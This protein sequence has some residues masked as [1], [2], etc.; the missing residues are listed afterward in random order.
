MEERKE[1]H[2]EIAFHH[3]LL[4]YLQICRVFAKLLLHATS[5]ST[6]WANIE[7]LSNNN[8]Y[9]VLKNIDSQHN[10]DFYSLNASI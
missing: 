1:L 6:D 9:V 7:V 10:I 2:L 5:I 4:A 3:Y 8:I